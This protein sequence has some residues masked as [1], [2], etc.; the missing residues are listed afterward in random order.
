MTSV[1][2][3]TKM[4]YLQDKLNSIVNPEWKE[5]GNDWMLA[6]SMETTEAIDHHGWKWWKKQIP[7]LPAVQM[8]L[9]DIWHFML[10]AIIE[11]NRHDTDLTYEKMAEEIAEFIN[12]KEA[13]LAVEDS[14]LRVLKELLQH[15][16][17]GTIAI[18]TFMKAIQ[19]SG[20]TMDDVFKTYV[21]KNVLNVFRQS[22]G[23]K[24]GEYIKDWSSVVLNKPLAIDR[25]LED[26]D[27][28]MDIMATLDQTSSELYDQLYTELSITYMEVKRST[29]V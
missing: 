20:M 14:L 29:V 22:N 21:G 19:L 23:Y 26:N 2:K 8:E 3:L 1:A 5:A 25:P 24:S 12:S 7:D 16:S 27:H 10:S 6:I 28:L 9:I 18:M 11:I 13:D 17:S 4:L 15:T